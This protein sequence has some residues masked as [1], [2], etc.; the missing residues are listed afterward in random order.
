[1]A[2]RRIL[3]DACFDGE[4]LLDRGPFLVTIDGG[5]IVQ[6]DRVASGPAADVTGG[7]L[8]PGLV[9]AHAHVF[10]DGAL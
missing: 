7:F 8:M 5:V 9:E 1:M 4:A 10:L 6:L 3:A 2:V